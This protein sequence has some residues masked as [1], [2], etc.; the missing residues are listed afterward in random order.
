MRHSTGSES[1]QLLGIVGLNGLMLFLRASHFVSF[2]WKTSRIFIASSRPLFLELLQ[3]HEND[4]NSTDNVIFN[5]CDF[6]F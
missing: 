2:I 5:C 3:T 6:S 1:P 4:D